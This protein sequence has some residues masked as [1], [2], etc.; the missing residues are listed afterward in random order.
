MTA[1]KKI[2]PEAMRVGTQILTIDLTGKLQAVPGAKDD[3]NEKESMNR[4]ASAYS[5]EKK[6]GKHRER[7]G[8]DHQMVIQAEILPKTA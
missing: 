4:L 8:I 2:D 7:K 1:E 6:R 5:V 3:I